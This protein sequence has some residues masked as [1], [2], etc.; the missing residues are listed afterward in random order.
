VLAGIFMAWFY[1]GT[2]NGLYGTSY[3]VLLMAKI[4]LLLVML[5]MGAGNWSV[6]RQLNTNPQPLLAR[7]RRFAEAE[8]GLGFTAILAAASMSRNLRRWTSRPVS[9]QVIAARMHPEMPRMKS[10]AASQLTPPTS[11]ETAVHENE[12]QATV[13]AM[14]WTEMVGI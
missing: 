12:F 1:V 8:V 5:L 2:W 6:V 11:I 10:P 13:P 9:L 3:G 7:L 14:P 4:Y